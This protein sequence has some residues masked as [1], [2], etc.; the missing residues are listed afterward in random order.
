MV[1]ASWWSRHH[2]GEQMSPQHWGGGGR[3]CGVGGGGGKNDHGTAD[4][5]VADAVAGGGGGRHYMWR[6]EQIKQ[7][8]YFIRSGEGKR[9]WL[10]ND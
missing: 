4:N 1:S 5:N 7:V 8:A 9:W 6:E 3:G 2:P 10:M